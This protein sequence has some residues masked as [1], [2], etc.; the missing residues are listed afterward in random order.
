MSSTKSKICLGAFSAICSIVLLV[1]V[2]GHIYF[3]TIM[4]GK[5]AQQLQLKNGSETLEKWSNVTVPI[6]MSFHMF[7]I[8]NPEEFG[9]GER[10]VVKQ[11]GPYVYREYRKKEI[12]GF[13]EE[14]NTVQY[15]DRK[16]FVFEPSMS[17]GTE[18]DMVNVINV[19][20]AAIAALTRKKVPE[21]AAPLIMPVLDSMIRKHNETLATR[22]SIRE[23]LFEGY[24][25]GLMR[26]LIRL[27]KAFLP[28]LENPLKNNTFGLFF[29]RNNSHDGL[30]S[31]YTGEDDPAKFAKLEQWNN[32]RTL[33]YWAGPTCNMING[34]DGGQFA[35][36]LSKDSTL[37]VFSTD[38]CRS[39][40][41]RYEK[42][43]EVH[44]IRTWRF[45]IPASLFESAD[46]REENRCFC[47]TAPVCP[48]SGIT[49]VAAC[50]KGAPI[51]LSSP[52]FYHGDEAFVRAVNGLRPVKEMHET[53]LDIHPLTGLVMRASKR[54][55]INV[56]LKS[57]DRLALL[58]NVQDTIFPVVWIEERAELA[59]SMAE[60][61]RQ[62]VELPQ[63][64][65]NATIATGLII[66]GIGSCICAIMVFIFYMQGKSRT[67]G[68]SSEQMNGLKKVPRA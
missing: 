22:R 8:T 43:T 62:K 32:Q 67:A 48:K 19:P 27:A 54:L 17:A 26:D 9:A 66:G 50:R 65:G 31:V 36:F 46:I 58:K 39:M 68:I 44:G 35:P 61:F 59:P 45:T 40:Y 25:V 3:P 20:V 30:Y 14:L 10:A 41:F 15:F 21:V 1:G 13:D 5:V 23:I 34:T 42:E 24:Q 33:K 64:V 38:L 7:N 6:Y 11:A 56:D 53:F 28:K 47:L 2:L 55:Q 29:E 60:E 52:H 16:T 12:Q 51:V 37:Y 63:K 49:H 4:R 57:N 18:D